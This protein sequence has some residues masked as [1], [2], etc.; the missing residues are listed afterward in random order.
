MGGGSGATLKQRMPWPTSLSSNRRDGP[1][2]MQS[3]RCISS[4]I[5]MVD[6]QRIMC[7]GGGSPC[8]PSH[9]SRLRPRLPGLRFMTHF[10]SVSSAQVVAPASGCPSRAASTASAGPSGSNTTS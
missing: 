2:P 1:M 9:A 10:A 5:S 3:V 6:A 7:L 4:S 8:S